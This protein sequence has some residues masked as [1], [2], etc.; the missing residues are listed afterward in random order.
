MESIYQ[1]TYS[2]VTLSILVEKGYSDLDSPEAARFTSDIFSGKCESKDWVSDI[3]PN[4]DYTIAQLLIRG[5]PMTRLAQGVIREMDHSRRFKGCAIQWLAESYMTP[6]PLDYFLGCAGLLEEIFYTKC[7]FDRIARDYPAGDE[8]WTML[9]K[10]NRTVTLN[11][12]SGQLE[13]VAMS[14]VADA[15]EGNWKTPAVKL[16]QDVWSSDQDVRMYLELRHNIDCEAHLWG[17]N[18]EQL[19]SLRPFFE[20]GPY[21]MLNARYDMTRDTYKSLLGKMERD[22]AR[23]RT[24]GRKI[25]RQ[26]QGEIR[27]VI[28][29]LELDRS[30][31]QNEFLLVGGK[32]YLEGIRKYDSSFGGI[33]THLRNCV[34]DAVIRKY[35]ANKT[36]T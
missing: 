26:A 29:N 27:E 34:A 35:W 7:E 15:L 30:S 31:D 10:F 33:V 9:K 4:T 11:F 8:L 5:T 36:E 21:D 22:H 6:K 14:V 20:I 16:E 13:I 3:D 2:G 24:L 23:S 28:S 19:K 12:P 25:I 18:L 1:G 17:L 32:G